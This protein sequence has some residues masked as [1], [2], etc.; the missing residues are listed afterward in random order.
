MSQPVYTS[1]PDTSDANY[2]EIKSHSEKHQSSTFVPR[3]KEL[4]QQLKAK[5]W[6]E[7]QASL[8]R[9]RRNY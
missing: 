2:W 9:K 6:V 5:A 7:I 1:I 4:H 3:D 8:D